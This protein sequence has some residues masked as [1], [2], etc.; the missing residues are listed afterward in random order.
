[1]LP[2]VSLSLAQAT[3]L[4]FV[5]VRC[6]DRSRETSLHR[7]MIYDL[8][9]KFVDAV[10]ERYPAMAEAAGL[11]GATGIWGDYGP[12]GHAE[13]YEAALA[14]LVEVDAAP[15]P[16]G[17][18]EAAAD[19]VLRTTI[20]N[21]IANYEAG[22]HTCNLNAIWSPLQMILQVF[23]ATP[24]PDESAW[25]RMIGRLGRA[26]EPLTGYR[27]TLQLGQDAGD[28]PARRQVVAVVAQARASG[29]PES[30]LHSL[31]DQ[32]AT[33][34]FGTEERV[35]ALESAIDAAKSALNAFADNL[36]ETYLPDASEEDAVGAERYALAARQ[37]L[38]MDLDADE[39]YQWGWEEIARLNEELVVAAL[40][41]SADATPVEAIELLKTDPAQ[42]VASPDELVEL[43]ARYQRSAV[44][45]LAGVHFDVPDEIREVDVKLDPPGSPLGAH[46][47]S[48]SED[49]SRP[50]TI[51]YSPSAVRP[52]P[53]FDE[54]ST[55]YHE[56]FPGHHLQ[57]GIAVMAGENLS[58]LHR[59]LAWWPGYGEGW[60]LYAERLMGELGLFEKPGYIVGML[61]SHLHRACRVVV[62]IG[63]HHKLV[64][65]ETSDFHPGEAWDFDL[66][67]EFMKERAFL[68]DDVARSEVTRY[69]GW[70]AQ[71]ISYK[72][73][74]RVILELREAEKAKP[75]FDLKAFHA[76][77]LGS[78]SVGLDF[79]RGLFAE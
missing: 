63:L 2:L 55:A 79:L 71:A 35:V 56:G 50:G 69:L 41:V 73:G 24:L 15:E 53:I 12:T 32:L 17:E 65:P 57:V 23:Q 20:G 72:L 10:V 5:P 13:A 3:A 78:G 19:Y 6:C 14:L 42:C 70:P 8:S 52:L 76:K 60:A 49:L 59:Q 28:M 39:A 36:E 48:P 54:I 18:W 25:E 64:I 58:R 46:Y 27:R 62:D 37:Y 31:A 67:V 33:S 40:E 44:E 68:Q 77:V 29:G 16:F 38:G 9:D 75:G 21:L 7:H 34:D 26:S 47:I 4:F 61:T 45:A 43:V 30:G 74:E 51:F 1:M 11:S 22:F 66:A